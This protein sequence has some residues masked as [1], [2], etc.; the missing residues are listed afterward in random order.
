[1][2]ERAR[3][4]RRLKGAYEYTSNLA[5]CIPYSKQLELGAPTVSIA[6][7]F[8][9]RRMSEPSKRL[10]EILE[11]LFLR[12]SVGHKIIHH[13]SHVLIRVQARGWACG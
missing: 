11:R 3:A 9:T 13:A 12:A 2:S 6:H 5:S 4:T 7:V 10:Q 8:A 1:M